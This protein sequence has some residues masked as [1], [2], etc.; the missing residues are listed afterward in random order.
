MAAKIYHSLG[1]GGT[2][3]HFHLGHEIFL[4]FAGQLAEVIFI[5]VT[6]EKMIQD[7]SF[8]A[9]IQ[10]FSDRKNAV[11]QFCHQQQIKCRVSRLA[12]P[13]GPTLENASVEALAVTVDTARGGQKINL[14]REKLKLRPLPI[15]V[16]NLV[17]DV[18]GEVI[19]SSRIRA[20]LINRSGLN[21]QQIFH[22]DLILSDQ[23]KAFFSQRQGELVDSP[24]Q[25]SRFNAVVGDRSLKFF[26]DHHWPVNLGVYDLKEK[27]T[28]N[29][30]LAV[31]IKRP[32]LT[33]VSPQGKIS[34]QLI[35]VLLQAIAQ[36]QKYILV[37]GEDD[38]AAVALMLLLPL[39]AHIYYGQSDQGMV[40]MAV[41]EHKKNQF[42][43]VLTQSL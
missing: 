24:E 40:E 10:P 20:G 16:C 38:L 6:D 28:D 12:D 39:A 1:L 35:K 29:K 21:Y 26:L 36:R 18:S 42:Y 4:K 7:K 33:A 3:D 9:A 17:K 8:A 14:L 2:F 22:Q 15:H 27:R 5:G 30:D 25:S 41:T 11:I 43:Q 23:Q 31:M 13:Y 32:D 37:Q 34:V 19:S